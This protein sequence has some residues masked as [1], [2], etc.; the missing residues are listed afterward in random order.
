[1]LLCALLA[2]SLLAWPADARGAHQQVNSDDSSHTEDVDDANQRTRNTDDSGHR[3]R[4]RHTNFRSSGDVNFRRGIDRLRDLGD[5]VREHRGLGIGSVVGN[6]DANILT[7][8]T[9]RFVNTG[10]SRNGDTNEDRDSVGSDN[11]DDDNTDNSGPAQAPRTPVPSRGRRWR[12]RGCQMSEFMACP[13]RAGGFKLV[14]RAAMPTTSDELAMVCTYLNTTANC[15]EDLASKCFP[16]INERMKKNN[17]APWDQFADNFN[18]FCGTKSDKFKAKFAQH[19]K[20]INEQVSSS[21]C[22]Q[23]TMVE[24][25]QRIAHLEPDTNVE[26]VCCEFD[27]LK[28]CQLGAVEKECGHEASK[29]VDVTI[30]RLFGRWLADACIEFDPLIGDCQW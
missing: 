24:I 23:S 26:Q 20:C 15:F 14:P 7:R 11:S 19:S 22:G 10:R 8:A 5:R 27:K 21:T 18:R 17:G 25:T 12:R 30:R 1:M 9:G 6:F 29:F 13:E 2:A 4:E 28:T 3:S 16:A